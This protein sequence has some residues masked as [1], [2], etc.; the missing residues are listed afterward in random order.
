MLTSYFET[1]L[2][3][4][5]ING[6]KFG[7]GDMPVVIENL[8]CNGTEDSLINCS[9][10]SSVRNAISSCN[11]A[12]VAGIVCYGMSYPLRNTQ[13]PL[14]SCTGM[15][16]QYVVVMYILFLGVTNHWTTNRIVKLDMT[17]VTM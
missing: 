17:S 12:T 15:S 3:G 6:S 7:A 4:H 13:Y 14:H 8:N 11:G 2:G 10:I 1:I 9:T 5:A 16:M